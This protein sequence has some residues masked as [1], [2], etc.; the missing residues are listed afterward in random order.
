MIIEQV[1]IE[2][3][4]D[5]LKVDVYAMRPDEATDTYVVIDKTGGQRTKGVNT[6]MVAI[7]SYAPTML[8]TIEL[9]EAVKTAMEDIVALPVIGGV[10]LLS[11]QNF[12]DLQRKV[13]RYQ[14][15]YQIT[16]Y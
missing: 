15:V 1:L 3:L 12:T 16:H 4:E 5:A 10:R 11:D 13:P 6:S 14:A 8:K 7:Q 2:Y 9:D